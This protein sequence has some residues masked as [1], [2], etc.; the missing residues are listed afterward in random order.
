L[1][2]SSAL[3]SIISSERLRSKNRFWIFNHRVNRGIAEG[4]EGDSHCS[5]C[6]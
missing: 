1:E 6:G 2:E 5:L 4:T 3:S